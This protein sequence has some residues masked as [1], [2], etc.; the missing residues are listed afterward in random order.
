MPVATNPQTVLATW[1]DTV[2]A[3]VEGLTPSVEPERPFK[4][5]TRRGREPRVRDRVFSVEVEGDEPI[6]YHG[7]THVQQLAR[8][9]LRFL[10]DAR[11]DRYLLQQRVIDDV[12]QVWIAVQTRGNYGST[13]VMNVAWVSR[14]DEQVDGDFR[15]VVLRFD[16]SR[17]ESV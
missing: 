7:T 15:E 1:L 10:Y 4:Q 14:A 12:K 17:R 8:V 3:L 16:V 6:G 2:V 11:G 13:E 5:D 9:A